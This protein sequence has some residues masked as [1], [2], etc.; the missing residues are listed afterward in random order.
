M[1]CLCSSALRKTPSSAPFLLVL[2]V[3]LLGR[4]GMAAAMIGSCCST[5]DVSGLA[6]RLG[7]LWGASACAGGTDAN[8][9][10][11]G[12]REMFAGGEGPRRAAA[13]RFVASE[14]IRTELQ[15]ASDPKTRCPCSWLGALRDGEESIE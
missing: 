6:A 11:E 12:R 5:V 4:A 15:S 3:G 10:A 9:V 1:A 13:L 8:S 14:A 2:P 7:R